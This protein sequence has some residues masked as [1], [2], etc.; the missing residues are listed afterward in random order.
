MRKTIAGQAGG[1]VPYSP[2]E[3]PRRGLLATRACHILSDT[4]AVGRSTVRLF[5][6]AVLFSKD[7]LKN[8]AQEAAPLVGRVAVSA[9]ITGVCAVAATY[10]GS[11]L[12][13][14]V[15]DVLVGSLSVA[16]GVVVAVASK[17]VAKTITK[18]VGISEFPIMSHRYVDRPI[19]W[20]ESLGATFVVLFS[21][22]VMWD[23][24]YAGAEKVLHCPQG[25]LGAGERMRRWSAAL[26]I[27]PVFAKIYGAPSSLKFKCSIIATAILA[28][29]GIY[30]AHYCTHIN[31]N[32]FFCLPGTKLEGNHTHHLPVY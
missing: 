14:V 3:A 6:N 30:C 7:L 1:V 4:V 15:S 13:N 23:R 9:A 16:A 27:I 18:R 8:V 2:P 20:I 29:V 32:A 26:L 17:V 21:K 19:R 10:S 31:N 22:Q 11:L 5:C 25:K 24:L 12:N 28:E